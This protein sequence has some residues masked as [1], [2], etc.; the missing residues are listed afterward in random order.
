MLYQKMAEIVQNR[1]MVKIDDQLNEQDKTEWQKVAEE[2]NKEKMDSF[3]KQKNID[4]AKMLIEE[5]II[6]KTEMMNLMK[7]AQVANKE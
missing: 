7:N 4:V 3:L 1:V 2:G 5:A 6:Y